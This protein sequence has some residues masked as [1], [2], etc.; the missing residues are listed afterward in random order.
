MHGF[1][2]PPVIPWTRFF[3]VWST[4]KPNFVTKFF[5]MSVSSVSSA[6]QASRGTGVFVLMQSRRRPSYLVR[7]VSV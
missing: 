5:A 6:S 7:I 2:G 1:E 3:L 4:H